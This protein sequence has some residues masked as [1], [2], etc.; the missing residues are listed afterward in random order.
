MNRFNLRLSVLARKNLFAILTGL[1]RHPSLNQVF[2]DI[3]ILVVIA[4]RHDEAI[5]LFDS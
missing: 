5:Y 2:N 1:T 3:L 4:R